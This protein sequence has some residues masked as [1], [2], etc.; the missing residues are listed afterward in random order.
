MKI[1]INTDSHVQHD[2]SVVRHVEQALESALGR[3]G[4]QL[5]R[6]EVHLSDENGQRGGGNDRVCTLE[7]RP[8][9]RPPVA[10]SDKADSI[11]V[12]IS[13]AARKLQHLL[14]GALAK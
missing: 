4:A 1:Q 13:G 5:T 8:A 11:A 9:G 12:A 2:A 14:D 3:F 10:V 7:A 6:I